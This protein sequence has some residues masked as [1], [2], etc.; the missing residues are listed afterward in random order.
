VITM[1]GFVR[2][3]VD[4]TSRASCRKGNCL[5]VV[6]TEGPGSVQKDNV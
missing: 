6:D 3:M 2:A 5:R 1:L 4:V